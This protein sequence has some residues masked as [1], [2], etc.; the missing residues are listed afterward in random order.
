MRVI[1]IFVN[2]FYHSE[3]KFGRTR[4]L[5]TGFCHSECSEESALGFA[6]CLFEKPET[7]KEKLETGSCHPERLVSGAK[8]TRL[9]GG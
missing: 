4:F 9:A 3:R 2:A 1:N 7:R 6:L 8:L 5:K